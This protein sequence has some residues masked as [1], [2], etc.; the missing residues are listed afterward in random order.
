MHI[1]F[2]RRLFN[3]M[4]KPQRIYSVEYIILSSLVLNLSICIFISR[5]RINILGPKLLLNG[6]FR[7]ALITLSSLRPLCRVEVLA[8]N[9]DFVSRKPRGQSQGSSLRFMVGR[10]ELEELSSR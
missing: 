7:Y 4:C 10:E 8:I 5:L 6:D 2:S 3:A 1:Y 9:N